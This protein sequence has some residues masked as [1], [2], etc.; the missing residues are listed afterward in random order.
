[1]ELCQKIQNLLFPSGIFWDKENEN[2]RT[3]DHNQALNIIQRISDSYKNKNE[4]KSENFSSKLKLCHI[5]PNHRTFIEDYLKILDFID[6]LKV[7]Y[8]EKA[9]FLTEKS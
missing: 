2:Y 3:F 1:L 9:K 7:A 5:V 8:P 6:W 4:E